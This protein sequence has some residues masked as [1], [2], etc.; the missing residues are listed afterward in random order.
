MMWFRLA[1]V[2]AA[3]AGGAYTA[4]EVAEI[5]GP[6]AI[7]AGAQQTFTD[8]ANASYYDHLLTGD[9]WT[10]ILKRTVDQ[11]RGNDHVS[12]SGTTLYWRYEANCLAADVAAPDS[13]PTSRQCAEDE[14]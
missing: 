2:S 8:I 4:Q 10:A 9:E 14:R 5:L 13:E 1:A 7:E 3:L 6:Q 11:A 12:V